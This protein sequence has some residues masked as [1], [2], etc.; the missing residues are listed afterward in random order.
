[1]LTQ[2]VHIRSLAHTD[3]CTQAAPYVGT[4]AGTEPWGQHIHPLGNLMM[5]EEKVL[6]SCIY[7]RILSLHFYVDIIG[8]VGWETFL[9]SY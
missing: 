8:E 1:M 9:I 2:K 3:M 7:R 5:V 4:A 6:Y